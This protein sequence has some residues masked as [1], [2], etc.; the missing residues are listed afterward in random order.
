MINIILLITS[1]VIYASFGIN[2]L[3]Y[4][5]F[6]IITS[7]I[8][9]RCFN[10][11][12]KKIILISTISINTIILLIMKLV[13]FN[14]NIFSNISSFKI[15][16][17]LGISYYTLQVISYLVDVYK[18]KNEPEKNL[19]NYML[20]ITYIP[21]LFI[22]PIYK[23]SDIKEELFSKRKLN[24]NNVSEGLIRIVLGLL[25]KFIISAR[26]A[27]IIS[28]ISIDSTYTGVYILFIT[29]LFTIQL[30]CDFSGGIDI[31]LGISKILGI[32]LK[33]NFDMPFKSESIK[34]FWRRWHITLGTW[35]KEYIYIPLGGNKISN[36]RKFFNLLITF[37]ISGIWHGI[38]YII[39]GIF[40]GIFVMF[41]D[42][43]K[44]KYKWI[45]RT[46][47]FLIVSLL[48]SFFI[49]DNNLY[50]LKMIGTIFTNF[51]ITHFINNFLNLGLNVYDWLILLIFTTFIL[52]YDGN[53]L[54]IK[55]KIL[56]SKSEFKL[57]FILSIALLIL[58][59]GIYGIGFNVDD[60]IYSK[61]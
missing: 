32:N 49:W 36:L 29:L 53:L 61:F 40:H 57:I 50:A 8:G 26:L 24:W 54:K 41:G 44:T 4:I 37:T 19:L 58:V 22:G 43:F 12:Y 51:N 45:N 7:Y 56:N 20:F 31:V 55:S 2:N 59:F 38:N 15:I 28:T 18:G 52:I 6:S 14:E 42:N 25:K 10:S 47:T 60:F 3:I 11:K 33:E 17:P 30:Y 23:Y 21:H 5:L 34:E 46:I 27:L 9:A 13:S 16:I 1:L 35:L 48:W 39:W